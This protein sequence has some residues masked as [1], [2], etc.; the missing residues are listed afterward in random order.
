MRDDQNDVPG[1]RPGPFGLP[2]N[3]RPLNGHPSNGAPSNGALRPGGPFT[4]VLPDDEPPID[5]V[6]VQADDE[7]VNA[8]AARPAIPVG[9]RVPVQGGGEPRAS[10]LD[11]GGT[12]DGGADDGG[13][14]DRLL[15]MLAA[16]RAEI[17]AEPI[18][19]LI[20]LDAAVAAVVAGVKAQEFGDR[21]KR[22]GR[23][24]QLAPLAAA[25]AI[26]VATVSGVGLGSQ[27]SMPGDTLWA[28]QKVVNPERA[29]SVE[30]KVA[31]E[32]RLEKVRSALKQGDTVTAA[33]ELEA[34]RTEI[35]VVR[36]QEGQPQLVQEQEFLAA[37]LADTPPGTPAD[38]STPPKS[39]PA[40]R[41]TGTPAPASSSEAPSMDS[42]A[43]A[44]S[45][46][47]APSEPRSTEPD[48]RREV[49]PRLAPVLPS[50]PDGRDR[51]RDR[52]VVPA[53]DQ[54]KPQVTTAPEVTAPDQKPDPGPPSNEGGKD[55][56]AVPP[57]DPAPESTSAGDG[58]GKP[59]GDGGIATTTSDTTTAAGRAG[60]AGASVET[61]VTDTT[62]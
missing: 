55:G 7:L 51:D 49:D 43:T 8:L 54:S 26:I 14:D 33:Q 56:S 24:R 12:D 25:A 30:A 13:T 34:I 45:V 21:R 17:D 29:E 48:V 5:L 18:P 23:I 32:G 9:G 20:D 3:G 61:T 2:A 38:L 60:S 31:V 4:R 52:V 58:E 41:S 27:N 15:A 1:G 50:A 57:D 28:I 11:E 59:A 40:A 10:G 35:P 36:G 44:P 22:A 62:T 6:A 47:S 53:P 39:N 42:S 46:S 16:W 37:K 19:E